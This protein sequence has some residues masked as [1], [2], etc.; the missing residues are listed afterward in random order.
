LSS[1]RVV[2]TGMGGLCALGSRWPEVREKLRACVSGISRIEEFDGYEGL[3]T[4]LGARAPDLERVDWPRKKTRGMGR[5]AELATRATELALSDAG[6]L[7]SPEVSDGT[8]GLVY[9]S[10]SGSPP[11]LVA[12]ANAFGVE[13]SARGVLPH[14]YARLMSHTCAA[15]LGQ[16]F[17]VRGRVIPV[18]SACT[19][20]SQAIGLGYEDIRDGRAELL[21]CGGAEELHVIQAALFDLMGAAS[22]RNH[23][24]RRT[25][26]PF[27]AERD[28]LVVG[29]GAA[30]LILEER[31]R[32]RARGATLYAE[33]VGYGTCCD[34]YDLMRPDSAGMQ[35]AMELALADAGCPPEE[36]DYVNAHATATEAGDIAESAATARVYGRIP[37]SSLKSYLGHT[38]GA[39]GAIEAWISIGMLREGWVA[40]TLNLEHVDPRCAEL[41]YVQGGPRNLEIGRLATNNFAFGGIDTSLVLSRV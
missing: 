37:V 29:E 14:D 2:V 13:R 28:G 4:R 41:D 34:G 7:G 33:I 16:F 39:C 12:Y 31:D 38:L 20:G 8:L 1:R 23:E 27:D 19:S 3:R 10:T 22:S 35:R 25:P 18:A 5:V 17:E 21:A 9:G 15:N 11:A 26:R 36:I 40:P 30:T 24:P 6:L 32:A